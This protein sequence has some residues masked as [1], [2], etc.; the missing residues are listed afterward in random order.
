MTLPLLQADGEKGFDFEWLSDPDPRLVVISA[1][2]LGAA[3]LAAAVLTYLSHRRYRGMVKRRKQVDFDSLAHFYRLIPAEIQLIEHI[4]RFTP[5]NN[6]LEVIK[7]PADFDLFMERELASL[8]RSEEAEAEIDE[9]ISLLSSIRRKA[10]LDHVPLGQFLH[11]TRELVANQELKISVETSGVIHEFASSV[12][13]ITEREIMISV[14][15]RE[16][17][18]YSL[19][20]GADLDVE[21]I[22]RNDAMYRFKSSVVRN[23]AARLPLIFIAHSSDLKRVQLRRHF[24]IDVDIPVEYR[25]VSEEGIDDA[26]EAFL[27]VDERQCGVITNIS[28]GGVCVEMASKAFEG[29][30]LNFDILLGEDGKRFN[31]ICEVVRSIFN[32]K[33][34]IAHTAYVGILESTRDEIIRFVFRRQLEMIRE[35]QQE[36]EAVIRRR[37][38][39]R[40][41]TAQAVG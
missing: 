26:A 29:D 39:A 21:L 15:S 17:E 34:D 8:A 2:I 12:V 13:R 38:A 18:E 3:I 4:A 27:G 24:R 11:S 23:F 30:L 16:G 19:D 5:E 32:G 41:I 36:I 40:E 20:E 35:E 22:R 37:A 10:G 28:G 33:T 9:A 25:R 7:S 1:C 31:V 14:P 6:P